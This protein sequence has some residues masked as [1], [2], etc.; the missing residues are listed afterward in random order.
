MVPSARHRSRFG[1]ALTRP[2]CGL[3]AIQPAVSGRNPDRT[4]AAAEAGRHLRDIDFVLDRNRN[5][6]QRTV[7]A[8]V[9]PACRLGQRLI[10]KYLRE[11]VQPGVERLDSTQY[12][13]SELD[14]GQLAGSHQFGLT[15]H[16]EKRQVL[17]VHPATVASG[18]G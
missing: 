9:I 7:P 5:A 6:G 11:G 16:S 14:R 18:C 12:E 1:A 15:G 2:R 8:V 13:F 3:P 4:T 17:L 10:G